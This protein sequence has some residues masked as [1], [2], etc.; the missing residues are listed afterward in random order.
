MSFING[1]GRGK[2]GRREG[3]ALELTPKSFYTGGTFT[4]IEK[5]ERMGRGKGR[6]E[7]KREGGRLL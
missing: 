7:K 2:R 3:S 1:E 6:K 5:R 4:R